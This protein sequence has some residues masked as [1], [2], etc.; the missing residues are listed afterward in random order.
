MELTL[1]VAIFIAAPTCEGNGACSLMAYPPEDSAARAEA[2]DPRGMAADGGLRMCHSG[3]AAAKYS[4][5]ALQYFQYYRCALAGGRRF[6]AGPLSVTAY[7]EGTLHGSVC[8][9]MANH[10]PTRQDDTTT[11]TA[12]TLPDEATIRDADQASRNWRGGE[13]GDA[14]LGSEAH[15]RLFSRMLLDTFNPYKPAVIDWPKLSED[16]RERLVNLPIWDIAVQTEGKARMRM[17]GYAETVSDPLVRE[18]LELNGFEE[19]RHKQVLANM[20][21]AYGIVLEPEPEYLKPRDTEWAY[22]KTG[23][24]ECIDSFFAFGLFEL[25]RRSGFFPPA[26]VATFEPVMQEECRHILFVVNWAAW[27]RR[28]LSWWQRPIFEL[29]LLGVWCALVWERIQTARDVGGGD[30]FTASGHEEMGFDVDFPGLMEVCLEE[31]DRRMQGYDERL[32]RP[33]L[34]PF[35]ARTVLR[36]TRRPPSRRRRQI[37]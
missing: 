24:S 11:Q 3:V 6:V 30:N 28:N 18:A 20:V 35:I 15:K 34:M 22:M 36:F 9:T 5:F 23:F 37:A 19:G 4:I 26:L 2:H 13:P 16:E 1:K 10:A 12:S 27:H 29:R 8:A 25:A 31:N 14:P 32:I 7:P 17:L 33:A 21:A